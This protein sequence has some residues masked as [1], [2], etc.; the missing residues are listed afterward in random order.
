[1]FWNNL[2]C[3]DH[4]KFKSLSWKVGTSNLDSWTSDFIEILTQIIHNFSK[5]RQNEKNIIYAEMINILRYTSPKSMLDPNTKMKV[6]WTSVGRILKKSEYHAY[7]ST[8]IS[9]TMIFKV[10]SCLLD[11]KVM[12]SSHV[13]S[14]FR[15]YFTNLNLGMISIS[16]LDLDIG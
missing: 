8:W 6:V 9:Q 15:S 13:L 5:V 7:I 3:L 12:G 10:I 4:N 2:V 1:L 11:L 16:Y 14:K